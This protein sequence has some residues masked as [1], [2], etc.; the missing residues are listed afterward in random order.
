[1][2]PMFHFEFLKKPCLSTKMVVFRNMALCSLIEI[3]Q[4][5]R[6]AYCLHNQLITLMVESVSAGNM[7]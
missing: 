5:F 7:G 1:M 6:V 4:R 3:D 2:L